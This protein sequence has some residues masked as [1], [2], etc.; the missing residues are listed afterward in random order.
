MMNS[1]G[2][3]LGT[4]SGVV[5][6]PQAAG[7]IGACS[8]TGTSTA[9]AMQAVNE[10]GA[11]HEPRLDPPGRAAADLPVQP[12]TIP[13]AVATTMAAVINRPS[14]VGHRVRRPRRLVL[15]HHQRSSPLLGG[16]SRCPLPGCLAAWLAFFA[17]LAGWPALRPTRR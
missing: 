7:L 17:V 9:A 12:P 1:P 16:P 5:L 2:Q 14:R 15:G 11:S 3:V 6:S 10:S 13:A 4:P 8:A